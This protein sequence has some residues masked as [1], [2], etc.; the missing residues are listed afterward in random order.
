MQKIL[1]A[2]ALALAGA[3][4]LAAPA[5][6]MTVGPVGAG[7][8]PLVQDVR[9]GCGRGFRPNNWGRCVPERG[10]QRYDDGYGQPRYNGGGYEPAQRFRNYEPA[11][12]RYEPAQ[13]RYR[14]G[15]P[16]GRHPGN[17]GRCVSDY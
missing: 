2:A 6:A 10:R 4:A 7:K 3:F 17:S 16:P 8:S 13:P 15:C 9:D 14:Q 5:S 1:I 11:Q 12:P